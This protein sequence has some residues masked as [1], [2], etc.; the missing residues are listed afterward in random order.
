[1][2]AKNWRFCYKKNEYVSLS[3]HV[4]KTVILWAIIG[5][6]WLSFWD[7]VRESFPSFVTDLGMAKGLLIGWLF[8]LWAFYEEISPRLLGRKRI[9][10]MLLPLGNMLLFFVY[11]VLK[12]SKI[13][14]GL[15]AVANTYLK[16][17]NAYFNSNYRLEGGREEYSAIAFMLIACILWFVIWNF[18]YA[19]EKKWILTAFPLIPL[20]LLLEVGLSPSGKGLD[21]LFVGAILLIASG[22]I[23]TINTVWGGT[24]KRERLM[25]QRQFSKAILLFFVILSLILSNLFYKDE[26]TVLI[27]KKQE[28]L[29]LQEKILTGPKYVD[30]LGGIGIQLDT[31]VLDNSKPV[32]T[33]REIL[34][35]TVDEIPYANI[36]LK[37]YYGTTYENS[38]WKGDYSYFSD[39]G[40]KNKQSPQDAAKEI[41][42]MG[43]EQVRENG[44]SKRLNYTIT[45]RYNRGTVAYI[46]YFNDF[47]SMDEEYTIKGD[48]LAE[49]K[50]FDDT[51]S[52]SSL[53]LFPDI[54]IGGYQIDIFDGT[55]Y[56][57]NDYSWYDDVV[58]DNNLYV[59]ENL[60]S[61]LEP[62]AEEICPKIEI[63]PRAILGYNSSVYGIV[64]LVK[65]YLEKNMTYNLELE[66]LPEGTDAVEYFL[67]ES[68]EGYCMHF[69]TAGTLLLRTLGI[70]ARYASG[71]V[72]TKRAFVESD[73]N[74]IASVKDRNAHAWV[75][76]YIGGL[77]WIPVEMTPGYEVSVEKLP[78]EPDPQEPTEEPTEKESESQ[79]TSSESS[80]TVVTETETQ[81]SQVTESESTQ[82]ET[83]TSTEA[84]G[85]LGDEK[86][87]GFWEQLKDRLMG[88]AKILI[89][90]L[91]LAALGIA[92][93]FG[94]R[95][96]LV[97]YHSVLDK[98]VRQKYN[99][100]AVKRIHRRMYGYL[101]IRKG[102]LRGLRDKEMEALLKETFAEV[103][104]A[105]WTLY[106]EIAKKMHYSKEEI[107]EEEML[108]AYKCYKEVSK[109]FFR[110]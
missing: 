54:Y 96:W 105:D 84:P 109:E 56:S 110:E 31:E 48:W 71:Y 3:E 50:I 85:S 10:R 67:Y 26:M 108:H 25:Y 51:I 46:P 79:E 65:E 99:R 45:Y 76:V 22:T 2:S 12:K 55:N 18:A 83:E 82:T 60:K 33:G 39:A 11:C 94:R 17:Y 43:Y 77:G 38:T 92:F 41:L 62:L 30:L 5:L 9:L 101:R 27:G 14:A 52:G 34:A 78:T 42:Q 63:S 89:I 68:K 90:I 7:I 72:V 93:Y 28:L 20:S 100:R 1:M 91:M 40:K 44:D 81:N 75:E 61:I 23:N 70:P 80:E 66:E 47:E 58:L 86:S 15:L 95:Q 19:F 97:H 73:S 8:L 6:F 13:M 36:Y 32:Y 64:S 107:T 106:M 74:Y 4:I 49:K 29:A 88:S 103:S 104:E 57:L 69:A 37:G 21:F 59:P 87:N 24:I 98:A 53:Q 16:S 102:L 35:I